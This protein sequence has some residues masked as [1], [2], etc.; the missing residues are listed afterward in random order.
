MTV[1]SLSDLS[2]GVDVGGRHRRKSECDASEKLGLVGGVWCGRRVVR[3][4]ALI[5]ADR[6]RMVRGKFMTC[7]VSLGSS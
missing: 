5:F 2:D 3:E 1:K 7:D 6:V 4:E